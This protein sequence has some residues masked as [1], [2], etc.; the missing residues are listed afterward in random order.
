MK[1]RIIIVA[2][3][4]FEIIGTAAAPQDLTKLQV[5]LRLPE[6]E[7]V[8]AEKV[9]YKQV[10]NFSLR[11]FI[12]RPPGSDIKSA[13][14]AVIFV[15]GVGIP[16]L[17]E[18][19]QYTGW[20]KLV[21][22]SGMIAVTYQSRPLSSREDTEDLLEYIRTHAPDLKIDADRLAIWACS[23][24]VSV[25]FPLIMQKE[26]GYIR[27]AVLYY[28]MADDIR[29]FSALRQDLPLFI[30]RA[31][32]DFY[33]LNKD[34][35]VFVDAALKADLRFE[36]VNYLEGHHGFDVYDN[37]DDSRQIMMR[38]LDFLKFNLHKP[39][40][41]KPRPLLTATNLSSL[42]AAGQIETAKK[43][44]H[45]KLNQ[46]RQEKLEN[47]LAYREISEAS[48][49]EVGR[50]LLREKKEKEALVIFEL[51][52]EAYPESP[53]VIN[54]LADAYEALGES[55]LAVKNAEKVLALLE[56][57]E[58]LDDEQKAKIR[59]DA[60]EKIRRLKKQ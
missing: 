9:V 8:E 13:L 6:M 60:A 11:A 28:G 47:P 50:D 32:L 55:A 7:K 10:D 57:A 38:T 33:G 54:N 14:P 16:S 17:P 36:L 25:G 31:G 58:N 2:I 21:A 45:E 51:A 41:S 19:G 15:N 40:Q 56:K 29:A 42:A 26:R 44:F 39:L 5:V 48:L 49:T 24:N 43:L 18:W 27:C 23:G 3:L 22:A 35:D 4:S 59:E 20:G 52:V 1:L 46:Y 53:V 12:Y 34:I 30:A 37:N